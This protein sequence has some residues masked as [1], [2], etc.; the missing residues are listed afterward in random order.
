[1][2]REL[3]ADIAEKDRIPEIERGSTISLSVENS[4]WRR[5]LDLSKDRLQNERMNE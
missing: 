2:R 1:M 3:L 5:L 4:L